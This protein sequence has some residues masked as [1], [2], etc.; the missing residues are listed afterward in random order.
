M[1]TGTG[2]R[3]TGGVAGCGAGVGVGLGEATAVGREKGMKPTPSG[4]GC[5]TGGGGDVD[6]SPLR[7]VLAAPL[8]WLVPLITGGETLCGPLCGVAFL[9]A[10]ANG[11]GEPGTCIIAMG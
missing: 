3:M 5:C 9:G 10:P 7:A 6:G 4:R 1:G 2:W 11:M 8:N